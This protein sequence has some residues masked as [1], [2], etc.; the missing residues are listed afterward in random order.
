MTFRY[1]FIYH[2]HVQVRFLTMLPLITSLQSWLF[3]PQQV[4]LCLYM[5]KEAEIP[6]NYLCDISQLPW[7]L[8]YIISKFPFTSNIWQFFLNY[9]TNSIHICK[10]NQGL[11]TVDSIILVE[12]PKYN[13][14]V[15]EIKKKFKWEGFFKPSHS[16]GS[17]HLVPGNRHAFQKTLFF[18]F[19]L[20]G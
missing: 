5:V 1:C 18:P 9:V 7:N 16:V 8:E 20:P 13:F 19:A 6:N 11:V 4:D 15:Y 12:L 10:P 2:N 3:W 14:V 17:K